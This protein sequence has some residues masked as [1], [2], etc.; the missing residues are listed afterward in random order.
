MSKRGLAIL[1]I[2]LTVVLLAGCGSMSNHT[3]EDSSG[4]NQSETKTESEVQNEEMK[5]GE[6]ELEESMENQGSNLLTPEKAYERM[7]SGDPIT[8]V[9][10]RTEE[11]YNAGHIE[12]AILIPNEEITDTKPELLPVMDAEILVYCRSGNRSGQAT[13]KLEEMGYTNVKDFGGIMDWPYETVNTPW[14]DKQGDLS[15]FRSVTLDGQALDEIFFAQADLTMV[16]V[17]ATFCGPCLS[18]MP[19]L[20][21]LS[22]EY[23]D[24]KVQIAGV[25]LDTLDS[26]GTISQEQ[27]LEARSLV[28]Q[29]G[30]NYTH[31]LP[32]T[33]LLNSGLDTIYTVPTTFFV[34]SNG[35]IVGESYLGSRSKAEWA[36]I[37]EELK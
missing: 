20:G 23:A 1:G 10:V 8:I 35:S 25:V 32:T 13:A 30:A 9:D 12:N 21:E 14:E 34:D 2:G 26:D 24:Q 29:T 3:K 19:E 15:S 31:M 22:A 5:T 7:E 16:N 17:W 6:K 36:Q 27:I 28:E 37:I 11:E 4:M 33:D 18:E